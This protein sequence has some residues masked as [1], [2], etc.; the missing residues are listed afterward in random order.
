MAHSQPS[1]QVVGADNAP[2]GHHRV[3]LENDGFFPGPC[4]LGKSQHV[5]DTL[6]CLA[7]LLLVVGLCQC[8]GGPVS[9]VMAERQAD[10]WRRFDV[11]EHCQELILWNR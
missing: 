5:R 6:G 7:V 9:I 2:R 8:L 1:H 10:H 3:P 4:Q 11:V